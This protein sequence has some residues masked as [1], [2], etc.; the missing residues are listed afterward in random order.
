MKWYGKIGYGVSEE[1]EPGIY[2]DKITERS[3]YGDIIR[4][5][6]INQQ[7]QQVNDDINLSNVLS[8]VAD[9]YARDK[10]YS[11]KYA[12]INNI[13]WKITNV[14]INYPRLMLT[15]GGVYNE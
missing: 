2:T 6:F 13:K 4:T 9:P 3:Y 1:T 15:I 12:I 7:R 11:M 14:E 5:S 8:I 10:F